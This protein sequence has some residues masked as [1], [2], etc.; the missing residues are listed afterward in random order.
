MSYASKASPWA[1]RG[2]QPAQRPADQPAQHAAEQPEPRHRRPPG[3]TDAEVAAI[4]KL[5]EALETVER[6]RGH[7]Y[8]FHQLT[9]AA[10]LALGEAVEG[11]QAAG[12][13]QLADRLARELIG[14]NVL[15]GR[16]TFQVVED[17][18]DA[19][20]QPFKAAEQKARDEVVAG[21]RHVH[22]AEMKEQRRT[23]GHPQHTAT[24][25]ATSET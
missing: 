4:G 21:R 7:L 1:A 2:A 11:L 20:Y 18:D 25:A 23:S 19:Y 8:E 5:S 15:P 12:R 17:Y 16:W 13:G 24:P 22:E 14:R 9:G 3:A 10:D 6:A